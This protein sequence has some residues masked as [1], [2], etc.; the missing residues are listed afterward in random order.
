MEF[1]LNQQ[2]LNPEYVTNVLE[3]KSIKMISAYAVFQKNSARL[4]KS[5]KLQ[6]NTY[7]SINLIPAPV[8]QKYHDAFSKLFNHFKTLRADLDRQMNENT[9]HLEELDDS[10]AEDS[11]IYK[12][13]RKKQGRLQQKIEYYDSIY[14]L[15]VAVIFVVEQEI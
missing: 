14:V 2:E 8:L 6:I 15:Y 3:S 1:P 10:G 12:L 11:F 13:Y 7:G 9:K 4:V 5:F